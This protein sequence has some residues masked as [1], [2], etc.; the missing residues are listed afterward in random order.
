M[1][2]DYYR[3][4]GVLDDAEDIVIRA[5]Y[6]ALAQRY[7]PDKWTGNKDEA[8][9]RMSEINEAYGVLSDPVKRKQYDATRE[10]KGYQEDDEPDKNF[11]SQ[12]LIKKNKLLN[13]N[14]WVFSIA[15]VIVLFLF[16]SRDKNAKFLSETTNQNYQSS[17]KQISQENKKIEIDD[18]EDVLEKFVRLSQLK[19]AKICY[20]TWNENTYELGIPKNLNV[21]TAITF[22]GT[23]DVIYIPNNMMNVVTQKFMLKDKYKI[24]SLCPNIN[25]DNLD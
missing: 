17:T 16:N 7:H 5:A 8:N 21:Y 2:K 22:K 25:L 11:Y 4:L 15:L 20:L 19:E 12:I 3:I 13:F 24:Q 9:K 14:W 18:A 1:S 6:K 10:N 23:L